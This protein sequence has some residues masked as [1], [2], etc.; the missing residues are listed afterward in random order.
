MKVKVQEHGSGVMPTSALACPCPERTTCVSGSGGSC[1]GGYVGS[2]QK[3][4]VLCEYG[5][6]TYFIR[7]SVTRLIKIGKT[8][9]V[10]RRLGELNTASGEGLELL[11]WTNRI[12]EDEA[13]ELF[14][15]QRRRNEWFA[16]TPEL[17]AFIDQVCGERTKQWRHHG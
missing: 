14:R 8:E 7:G 15:A 13:H 5:V 9:S 12:T 4:T 6:V 17:L 16:E 2:D 3:D 1:C 10:G 11:G